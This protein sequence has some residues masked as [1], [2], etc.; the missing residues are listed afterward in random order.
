MRWQ[1]LT[2]LLLM[3]LLPAWARAQTPDE[4]IDNAR[5]TLDRA[6]LPVELLDDRVAEGRAKSIAAPRIAEAVE[7]R[8]AALLDARAALAPLD[9]EISRA[10]LAAGADAVEAGLPQNAIRQVASRARAE[11]RPVALAV[12]T[13]LHDEQGLPVDEA[14][15]RVTEALGQGPDALRNLPV[16]AA[17]RGRAVDPPGRG[18]GR[19]AGVGRP[20]DP[21]PPAGVP[22][23]GG[24]PG[25]ARPDDPGRQPPRADPGNG[26]GRGRP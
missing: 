11:D 20:A 4:R 5:A 22:A 7:R 25:A 1:S 14:V 19:S 18:R 21:G 15:A 24:R 26:Q 2:A 13:F 16:Q 23:P 12:L 6:G 8:A 9:A 17:A 10:E 3:S